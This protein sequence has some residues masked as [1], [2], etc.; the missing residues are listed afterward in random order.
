MTKHA[1]IDRRPD[2]PPSS[3]RTMYT[4][5]KIGPKRSKT[6]EGF[7]LC[8][9]VALAR[10]G[11]MVYAQGQ[12]PIDPG[13]NGYAMICRDAETLFAD[14]AILSFNGKAV[15]ND[16]P[17][18]GVTPENWKRVAIGTV[19]NVRRGTGDDADVMLGD[20]LITDAQAIR[21]IDAGKREV[22]AGYD[23]DYEQTGDG[24][25]QQVSILGNHI[26]LVE[27]G[28]C[29]PRCAIGDHDDPQQLPT[30][31]T[32]GMATA[33][34]PTTRPRK[35]ISPLVRKL[36]QDRMDEAAS[37]ILSDPVLM[38]GGEDGDTPDSDAGTGGGTHVHVHMHT[39]SA[40]GGEGGGA[41]APGTELPGSEVP[42]DIVEPASDAGA[43]DPAA[44]GD[45][46]A[47]VAKLESGVAEILTLLKGSTPPA[48]PAAP[49]A[50][51]EFPPA[52]E[53]A[54]PDGKE[55]NLTGDSKAL[56]TGFKAVVADAEVLV[57][58]FQMP[59]FDPA[60]QRKVTMDSMCALRRSV[61]GT[62]YTKNGKQTVDSMTAGTTLD[63]E[64]MT[65]VQVADLF[66]NA[67]TVHR[68][69]NNRS[70]TG[71][72]HKTPVTP[73]AKPARLS[74]AEINALNRKT[75]PLQ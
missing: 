61:L 2:P 18:G 4:T 62:F 36:I 16:H 71:D 33:A 13:P 15:T 63:L 8:Q 43:V 51:D 31:R 66:R 60:A 35:V 75:Y 72:A 21:D 22:S 67:A 42:G 39:G 52:D 45:I 73:P 24:L 23:A 14:T 59:T 40:G 32:E 7:L 70:M 53:N 9:D 37:S 10:T 34:T 56:E 44:G 68:A 30:E 41:A 25:G 58:G 5:E 11:W 54:D 26:A 64:P 48:K 65:C 17:S 57:P 19:H 69:L 29:G 74:I 27:R 46:G 50:G 3:S 49:N 12:T 55:G 38:G 6:P 20:L 47:R 1:T 28:R